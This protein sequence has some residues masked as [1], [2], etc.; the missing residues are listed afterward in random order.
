MYEHVKIL[1]IYKINYIY[2]AFKVTLSELSTSDTVARAWSLLASSLRYPEHHRHFFW[3]YTLTFALVR[4][5]LPSP[6]RAHP[7]FSHHSQCTRAPVVNM[8]Q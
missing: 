3:L 2:V 1:K 5:P 7:A 4:T 8:V 6:T